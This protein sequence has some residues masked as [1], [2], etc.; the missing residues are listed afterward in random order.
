MIENLN[1]LDG[2]HEG[3]IVLSNEKSSDV[4]FS[5][6][7]AINLFHDKAEVEEDGIQM[8]SVS[9]LNKPIFIPTQLSLKR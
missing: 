5:S 2:M 1:F 6:Q 3:L 7:P 9:D 4:E 8:V